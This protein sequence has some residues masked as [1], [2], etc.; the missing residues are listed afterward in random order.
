MRNSPAGRTWDHFGRIKHEFD[1][2]P[3]RSSYKSHRDP[4]KSAVPAGEFIGHGSDQMYMSP[5]R[6]ESRKRPGPDAAETSEK[7]RAAA[8]KHEKY[9]QAMQQRDLQNQIEFQNRI[10]FQVQNEFEVQIEFQVQLEFENQPSAGNI[11]PPYKLEEKYEQ[12]KKHEETVRATQI[13]QQGTGQLSQMDEQDRLLRA[14][15][16]APHKVPVDKQ[17]VFEVLSDMTAVCPHRL[18]SCMPVLG[19]TVETASTVWGS[20]ASPA[21]EAVRSSTSSA[22]RSC[23]AP[24]APRWFTPTTCART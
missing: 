22:A 15:A 5:N 21:V 7:E 16:D 1:H 20:F 12:K 8:E 13:E 24:G 17:L 23:N 19:D 2:V 14:A 4:I 11:I 3:S 10:E 18:A 6:D 9:V